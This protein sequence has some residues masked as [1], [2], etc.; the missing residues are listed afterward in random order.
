VEQPARSAKARRDK[1]QHLGNALVVDLEFWYSPE[2][3]RHHLPAHRDDQLPESVMPLLQVLDKY[4]AK[5]TFAVLGT[6]AERYPELVKSIHRQGHEIASHGYSHRT[7][8]EM[9]ENEF[10]QE[11][12]KSV[13]LLTAITGQRPVGFR[14]PSFSLNNSTRWALD[15]LVRHGF[16]Y[17]ASVFPIRTRLYGV[18]G[19]PLRP[20]RPSAVDIAMESEDGAIVEFPM[21]VFRLGTNI[22]VAGGFYLRAL[23]FSFLNYA[24]RRLARGGPIVVYVHPWEMYNG[25]PRLTNLPLSHRFVTYYG[26][27]TALAKLE[28]LVAEF[29]FQTIRQVLVEEGLVPLSTAEGKKS[30]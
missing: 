7:L 17:D 3:V 6:V 24:L 29:R 21:T 8:Y 26:I 22:P 25:T 19:A 14:A 9:S 1:G 4:E 28:R 30:I 13:D 23:P 5:A 15:V 20:Y 12:A 2:F 10:D 18:P 16:E 27:G 11:I